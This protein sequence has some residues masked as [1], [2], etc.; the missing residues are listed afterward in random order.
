[1][2]MG[3]ETKA[4]CSFSLPYGFRKNGLRKYGFVI[5]CNGK[6]LEFVAQNIA[7]TKRLMMPSHHSDSYFPVHV[8]TSPHHGF[9]IVLYGFEDTIWF[10][11]AI[12]V[13]KIILF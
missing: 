1:M 9:V 7:C 11:F 12:R 10:C 6:D 4:T 5:F 2:K 8:R 13:M 3:S